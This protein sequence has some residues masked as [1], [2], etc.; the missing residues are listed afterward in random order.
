M[1][2]GQFAGPTPRGWRGDLIGG[3]SG[4]S[5]EYRSR[6]LP[7]HLLHG[8]RSATEASAKKG[9]RRAEHSPVGLPARDDRAP[10]YA[11]VRRTRLAKGFKLFLNET[12]DLR[13]PSSESG[14]SMYEADLIPSP[15]HS[16]LLSLTDLTLIALSENLCCGDVAAQEAAT[17]LPFHLLLRLLAICG[18]DALGKPLSNSTIKVLLMPGHAADDDLREGEDGLA[19]AAGELRVC[20]APLDATSTSDSLDDWESA[21]DAWEPALLDFTSSGIRASTLRAV[22]GFDRADAQDSGRTASSEGNV[23]QLS[24]HLTSTPRTSVNVWLRHISLAE[25]SISNLPKYLC[26]P[27]LESLSLAG[28]DATILLSASVIPA[29]A[30]GILQADVDV[31]RTT[32]TDAELTAGLRKLARATP[33]LCKLDLSHCDWVNARILGAVGW[34]SISPC[35]SID[36]R[37]SSSTRAARSMSEEHG[38]RGTWS[39]MKMLL[40]RAPAFWPGEVFEDEP[41]I[42]SSGKKGTTKPIDAYPCEPSEPF[43]APWHAANFLTSAPGWRRAEASQIAAGAAGWTSASAAS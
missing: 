30:S 2:R 31:T 36:F 40:V 25:C 37:S 21:K 33:K 13:G 15:R 5:R 11:S 35:K 17:S 10:L 1:V 28:C 24:T 32:T 12:L 26:C 29:S 14:S 42:A 6:N 16:P 19:S 7:P 38:C 41:S 18:R 23:V 9:K 22:L 34:W 3:S 20:D 39:E 4:L 43:V 8:V 27:N